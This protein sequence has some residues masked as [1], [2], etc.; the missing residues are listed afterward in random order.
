MLP[1]DVI[2]EL[3]D[4][5]L[6]FNDFGLECRFRLCAPCLTK[7]YISKGNVTRNW[8]FIYTEEISEIVERIK[9]Y[10]SELGYKIIIIGDNLFTPRIGRQSYNNLEI[11]FTNKA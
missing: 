11:Y 6:E 2:E 8:R 7:V 5:C 9:D 1:D 4:I 10:V 3:K